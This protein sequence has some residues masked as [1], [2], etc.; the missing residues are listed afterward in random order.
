MRLLLPIADTPNDVSE[1][2]FILQNA[3]N[4]LLLKRNKLFRL[5]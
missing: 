5:S 2:D 1:I 3:A 4:S